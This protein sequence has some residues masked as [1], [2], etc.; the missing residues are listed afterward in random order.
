MRESNCWQILGLAIGW[1]LM[2]LALVA[3]ICMQTQSNGWEVS[4]IHRD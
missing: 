4:T 3:A 2:V 1:G